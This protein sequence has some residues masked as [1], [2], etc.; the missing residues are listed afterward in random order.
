MATVHPLL[1]LRLEPPRQGVCGCCGG[2][3]TSLVRFVFRDGAPYA[4]YYAAF[5]E[6]HPEDGVRALVSLGDWSAEGSPE[7][8]TAFSLCLVLSPAGYHV[9]LLAGKDSLWR[10]ATLVGRL[11]SRAEALVHPLVNEALQIADEMVAQDPEVRDYLGPQA[12]IGPS[13]PQA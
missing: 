6:N 11:L 10:T 2:R 3:T 13:V 12:Q 5:A 8:R 7:R 4:V 1:T 9:D